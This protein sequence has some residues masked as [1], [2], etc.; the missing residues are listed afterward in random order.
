MDRW[1]SLSCSRFRKAQ[2]AELGLRTR[3]DLRT[4]IH[5]VEEKFC[6]NQQ[7]RIGYQDNSILLVLFLSMR[8]V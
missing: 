7:E 3:S 4:R 1:Y 5:D 8:H 6:Q 2:A